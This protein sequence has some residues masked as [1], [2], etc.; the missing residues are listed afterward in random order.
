MTPT[1]RSSIAGSPQRSSMAGILALI[2]QRFGKQG[3]A[4]YVLYALAAEQFNSQGTNTCNASRRNGTLPAASCGFNDIT[5][6][7]MD[8]PCGQ[9]PDGNFYDCHGASATLIGELSKDETRS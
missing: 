3:N 8:I 9:N 7:D 6:W 1:R 5:L 4:N 2:E